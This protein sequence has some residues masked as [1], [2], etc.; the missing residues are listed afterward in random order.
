MDY[1]R[2]LK[3][4]LRVG[5]LDLPDRRK[6]Y[7]SSREEKEVATNMCRCGMTIESGTHIMGEC[8]IF[9]EDRDALEEEVRKL[10]VCDMEEFGR[11]ESSEQTTAT[12]GD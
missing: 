12:S 6:R 7:A 1:A 9:K 5:G 10:V 3:L 8:E 4:R 2:E 11:L